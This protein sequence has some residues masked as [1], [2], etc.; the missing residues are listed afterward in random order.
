MEGIE[1][2]LVLSATT[3]QLQEFVL[4]RLDEYFSFKEDEF[5]RRVSR[6]EG[7][8]SKV[9]GAESAG[10]KDHERKQ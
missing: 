2:G 1:D 5:L 8:E 6:P 10:E 4:Q 9:D 3:E 7:G